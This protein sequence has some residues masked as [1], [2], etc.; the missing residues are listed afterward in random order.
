MVLHAHSKS[1]SPTSRLQPTTRPVCNWAAQV[2]GECILT[3]DLFAQVAAVWPLVWSSPWTS[4]SCLAL[5]C[6]AT[7]MWVAGM[8]AHPLLIEMGMCLHTST[9]RTTNPF[10][11]QAAKSE[12]L[13]T[14]VLNEVKN[15]RIYGYTTK[16]TRIDANIHI[17]QWTTLLLGQRRGKDLY[18]P[19]VDIEV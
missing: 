17:S 4:S 11:P 15:W 1:G 13:G 18:L 16:P 10:S 5:T 6:E 3:H 7:F 8:C 9:Q 14:T 19:D 12:R 2:T